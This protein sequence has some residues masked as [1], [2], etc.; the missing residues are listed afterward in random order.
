M[1]AVCTV[2][3]SDWPISTCDA[4]GRAIV[5]S[6]PSDAVFENQAQRSAVFCVTFLLFKST[7][8]AAFTL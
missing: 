1:P 3:L 2:P 8:V 7:S 4:Q 6:R 5:L